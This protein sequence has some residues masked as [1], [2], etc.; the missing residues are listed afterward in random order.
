[1]T[2]YNLNKSPKE[3]SHS[4]KYSFLVVFFVPLMGIQHMPFVNSLSHFYDFLHQFSTDFSQIY[5]FLDMLLFSL[6]G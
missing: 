2:M 4:S 3:F 5:P 6:L 1:M